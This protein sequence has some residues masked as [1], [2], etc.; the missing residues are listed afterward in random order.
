M[1]TPSVSFRIIGN[2]GPL[3]L[4]WSEGPFGDAVESRE[5]NGVVWLSGSGEL[6]AAEFDDVNKTQ[7]HQTLTSPEGTI[8]EVTV[9]TG[10]VKYHLLKKQ[11]HKLPERRKKLPRRKITN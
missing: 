5:G 3:S 6:L 1:K 11:V 8:I 2:S 9:K 7:D 10:K 4:Y